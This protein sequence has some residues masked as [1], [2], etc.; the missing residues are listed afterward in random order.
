MKKR[1]LTALL[2]ALT[3]I[4]VIGSVSV[5]AYTPYQTYTYSID[6][7]VLYSPAAYTPYKAIDA[8]H[9]FAKAGSY[10]RHELNVLHDIQT[11]SEGNVYLVDGKAGADGYS[12]VIVLNK[13]YEYKFEISSFE[14]ENGANDSLNGAKGVFVN[15]EYIYICDT[16]NFRI[17]KFD[18]DG[19]Y[20]GKIPKPQSVLFGEDA[21]YKPIAMAVDEY[22]RIFVVSSTTYQGVIV[23]TDTGDF[24]GFIGA[25]KVTYDVFD[26]LFRRFQSEAQ[27]AAS[28]NYVSTEFNN[29]S[30]DSDGFIYATTS[31]IKAEDQESA[32]TSKEADY[33]P[34]KKLNSKGD[35]IMRRNGFF[36]PVG[37]VDIKSE[38]YT[39]PSK[40]VDTGIGPDLTWSIIDQTR[41]KIFT[42]DKNGNLLFAFGDKG[43]QL[44]NSQ[45][46]NGIVYQ[47]VNG[48]DLMLVL[49]S[50]SSNFTVYKATNYGQYIYDALAYEN[51]NQYALAVDAWKNVLMYNNNFD[52]AYIGVGNSYYNLGDE[53]VNEETGQTG[54]ELAIEYYKSAYDTENYSKAYTEIRKA[55]VSKFILLIPVIAFIVIFLFLKYKKFIKKTNSVAVHKEGRKTFVEELCYSNYLQYHPFDGFWDLKHEYRGSVRAGIAIIFITILSFFY[56]SLGQ[57]YVLNPRGEFSSIFVQIISVFVP[58]ILWV[59]SNWCL[60]TLFDGEGSFK[61]IFIASSYSLTPLPLIVIVTT[62]ASNWVTESE[63]S[64]CSF[65]VA[66]AFVWVA[67]LLFFGM[68]VTHDYSMF[69]NIVITLATILGMAVIIFMALLFSSLIGKM[70]SFISSIITE[71]G[72]RI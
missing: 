66:L 2:L 72:Y 15:D 64:L 58:F 34:V 8:K 11:D 20:V 52:A 31:T 65:F 48:Y 36:S 53:I 37:E 23:M 16:D 30:I 5:S 22:G 33:S 4:M 19:N 63:A 67:L 59:I 38:T 13:E 56:Q 68:M 1:I 27:K 61:D 41:N 55:W 25:Q 18:L 35:E 12:R 7:E 69:K 21:I 24:T 57:G 28:K 3:F 40:I 29:I 42:Y 9:V 51:A 44:G 54:Y 49:D 14:N 45:S 39:G 32:T 46:I 26:M 17:L 47:E 62:I 6:G 50:A 43:T 60:T 70:I 71:I 10:T